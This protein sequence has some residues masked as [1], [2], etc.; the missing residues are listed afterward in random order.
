M[1]FF[2]TPLILLVL[3]SFAQAETVIYQ[4]VDESGNVV[5]SDHPVVGDKQQKVIKIQGLTDEQTRA[6]QQRYEKL[7]EQ[8]DAINQRLANQKQQRADQ[9]A[10]QR[11]LEAQREA[12]QQAQAQNDTTGGGG[13]YYVGAP[14]CYPPYCDNHYHYDHPYY[15]GDRPS[16]KGNP[17]VKP[18]SQVPGPSNTQQIINHTQNFGSS[19]SGSGRF[20]R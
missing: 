12:A 16:I 2:Y 19:S 8:D 13:G 20:G 10:S 4:Q 11:Q 9:K 6:A 5:F 3:F 18:N 15:T 17:V 1:R 14:Y 7:L